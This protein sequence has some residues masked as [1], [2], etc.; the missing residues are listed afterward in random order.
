M[1]ASLV[2]INQTYDKLST[3]YF[4]LLARGADHPTEGFPRELDQIRTQL[5]SVAAV[6]QSWRGDINRLNDIVVNVGLKIKPVLDKIESKYP[7]GTMVPPG[8]SVSMPGRLAET[9][10]P[11]IPPAELEK[12]APE[13]IGAERGEELLDT[14]VP[15]WF[16][17]G[18]DMRVVGAAV[19]GLGLLAFFWRRR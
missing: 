4:N 18:V 14:Y 2:L 15:W 8:S 1:S 12:Q 17:G 13:G 19:V 7:P 6:M 11:K 3:R 16:V 5:N 10:T 9:L